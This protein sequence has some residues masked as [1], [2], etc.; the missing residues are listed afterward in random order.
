MQKLWPNLL[1]SVK[2]K[3]KSL[4][5]PLVARVDLT[6]SIPLRTALL[7]AVPGFPRA[8]VSQACHTC[9]FSQI[10]MGQRISANG[11]HVTPLR[12]ET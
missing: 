12:G 8:S 4:A 10:N 6:P 3:R 5:K 9:C 7:A 2:M 1:Y 11:T